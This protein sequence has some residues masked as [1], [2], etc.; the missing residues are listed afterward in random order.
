MNW[1]GK[2]V[3]VTGSTGMIGRELIPLL[4][5]AGARVRSVSLD[6]FDK[7]NLWKE[8]EHHRLDLRSLENC[9]HISKG[10]E[11]VFHLAGIKGSPK[12]TREKPYTFFTNTILFNTNM[13][14]AAKINSAEGYVYTSSIGVYN[15]ESNFRESDM[16]LSPPSNEDLHAGY[17]KRMGEL[18][19]EALRK[20][21]S[22]QNLYVIRPANVYGSWDNFDIENAMVIPSLIA[23]MFE[24]DSKVLVW[25][26]GRPRRDFIHSRDVARAML[27]V[28]KRQATAPVNVGSG[29][30]TSIRELVDLLSTLD[31]SKT[32]HFS[33]SNEFRGDN[34]RILNTEYLDSLGFSR[35][36]ELRSG[37]EE[38]YTW[39]S[40]NRRFVNQRFNAFKENE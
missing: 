27:H 1:F 12:M 15:P 24:K 10:Q 21:F 25:G 4:L 29:F 8:I 17:A 2:R 38:T 26:D 30:G 20:E 40:E 5:Q 11:F 28:V 36:V 23:K 13:L 37:L 32:F 3:L 31:S 34:V 7:S 35:E 39:Y 22:I 16:W 9:I 19:I 33:E 6:N 18:Q 14:E